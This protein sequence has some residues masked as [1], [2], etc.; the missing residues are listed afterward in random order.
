MVS[1]YFSGGDLGCFPWANHDFKMQGMGLTCSLG[2]GG[3][4]PNLWLIHEL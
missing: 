4:S 3:C 2:G 1:R